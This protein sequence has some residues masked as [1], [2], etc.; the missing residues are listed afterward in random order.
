MQIQS[1]FIHTSASAKITSTCKKNSEP[2]QHA[3]LVWGGKS[4]QPHILYVLKVNHEFKS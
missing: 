3:G 2:N 1:I 4:S